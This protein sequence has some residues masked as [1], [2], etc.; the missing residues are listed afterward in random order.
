VSD[1]T[2]AA[3]VAPLVALVGRQ[4]V[5]KS[6]LANR[7]VGR[8]AAIAHETPGVT[9][10]RVELEVSWRA[11]SFRLVDT[12]GFVARARGVDASVTAQAARAAESADLVLLV[13]DAV[14][15]VQEEDASL[16]RSLLRSGSPVLVVANKVD[17]DRHEP[18]AAEFYALGL[19]EPIPV[20]ALHGRGT[21]ELLDRILDL[22]PDETEPRPQDEAVFALVGRPNVG[23]S[24][25]FNHLVGEDRAVVHDLPGTTRDAVDTVVTLDGHRVRFVDTAG[26]RRPLRTQGVEYYGLLRAE[27]AIQAAHV[28]LLVI[29]AVEGVTGEDLRIAGKVRDAG[30][31][32][33]AV[34]NKWDLIPPVDRAERFERLA[35]E[36]RVI[37]GAQVLRTSAITGSGVGRLAGVLLAAHERWG[38]RIPT[39]E[40]NRVLEKATAAHP[41]PRGAGRIRY[42]TQ[43]TA[44]PPTFVLF[45]A[46]RVIPSYERYLEN[47]L[48]E[49]F[50]FQGIPVRLRLRGRRPSPRRGRD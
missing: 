12:G 6:T 8:R 32:L 50:G 46:A 7:L 11:R 14:T 21:G 44:G 1:P 45:G 37:P 16:A 13:V 33:A 18:A 41:P 24:S 4:N 27:Q 19:G 43:V 40:V 30:R 20:S 17:G 49:A 15:G 28:A 38:R 23:K 9:R 29:D 35:E 39:A 22:I 31:G 3:S 10:D 34:L 2:G 36:V 42:G 25:L 26:F 48:R 47:T 5:G